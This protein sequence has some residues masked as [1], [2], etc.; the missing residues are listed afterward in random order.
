MRGYL[1]IDSTNMID[2]T[3]AAAMSEWIYWARTSAAASEIAKG[4]GASSVTGPTESSEVN[5]LTFL[6]D[7]TCDEDH[8]FSLWTCIN[9]GQ[10]CS[11]NGNCSGGSC[12]CDPNW[13]GSFCEEAIVE[14]SSSS[15]SLAIILGI[16]IPLGFLGCLLVVGL[17]VM[18][19]VLL[20]YK[21]HPKESW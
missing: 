13:K 15:D 14:N 8:V 21:R 19:V 3:K 4:V 10:M 17:I 9:N 12:I 18:F 11:G 1:Y 16:V 2:C 7:F 20:R 5:L 6:H